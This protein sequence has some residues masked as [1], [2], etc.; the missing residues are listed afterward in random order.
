MEGIAMESAIVLSTATA[1]IS[2]RASIPI[3]VKVFDIFLPEAEIKIELR[4]ADYSME[5]VPFL[6]LWHKQEGTSSSLTIRGKPGFCQAAASHLLSAARK[7][8]VENLPAS[9]EQPGSTLVV[10]DQAR[11]PWTTR[12]IDFFRFRDELRVEFTG[13]NF[14]KRRVLFLWESE[15]G[16]SFRLT[17]HGKPGFCET[18]VAHLSNYTPILRSL[19]SL[20]NE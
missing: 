19:L 14:E 9:I 7:E 5:R 16:P 17:V 12:I 15:K 11:I 6:R 4:G 1:P 10:S 3:V 13:K 20:G 18:M 8:M 2:I